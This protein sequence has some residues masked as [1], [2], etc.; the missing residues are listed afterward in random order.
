V[1]GSQLLFTW[2]NIQKQWIQ[3]EGGGVVASYV[4]VCVCS[5]GLVFL[6]TLRKSRVKKAFKSSHPSLR[7]YFLK[8]TR[9]PLRTR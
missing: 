8:I 1:F 2:P 9:S 3:G 6:I 7:G 5:L 4:S